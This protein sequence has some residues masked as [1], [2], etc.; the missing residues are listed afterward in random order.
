MNIIGSSIRSRATDAIGI[1]TGIDKKRLMVSFQYGGGIPVPLANYEQV[2]YV[3]D[4][5]KEAIYNYRMSLKK[6]RG[7][8]TKL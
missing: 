5:L 7:S 1:I 2:L 4:D 3:S 8:K 6:Q